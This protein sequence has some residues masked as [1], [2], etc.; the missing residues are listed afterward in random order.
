MKKL[1][2][3]TLL[4]I[5]LLS[6][7]NPARTELEQN[8][9]KWTQTNISHYR[10]ELFVGCF[11]AFRSEMPLT[12]EIKNGEIVSITDNTGNPVAADKLSWFEQYDTIERLFDYT[13]AAQKNA[14]EVIVTYDS[15][16][17]FPAQVNI[18]NI[19]EAVDDELSLSVSNFE[20]LK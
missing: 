7:C 20:I 1:L 13:A 9:D 12:I 3:F 18:D 10:F 6:A 15:E 19:K 14:D 2:L 16:Y 4:L 11:C 17:G 8:R 5:I